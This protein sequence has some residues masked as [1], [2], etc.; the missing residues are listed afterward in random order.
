MFLGHL[1]EHTKWSPHL[2]LNISLVCHQTTE[3]LSAAITAT[4]LGTKLKVKKQKH[5]PK[6]N[7]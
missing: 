4:L 6:A 7:K 1:R 5:F 3:N 2:E